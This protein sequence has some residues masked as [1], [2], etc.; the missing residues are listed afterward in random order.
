MYSTNK[1]LIAR[2]LNLHVLK[3]K[4]TLQTMQTRLFAE[5]L[6]DT[7]KDQA[8]K[9]DKKEYKKD[10]KKEED[11]KDDKKEDEKDDKKE[12]EKEVEKYLSKK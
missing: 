10:D 2:L 12:D 7:Q 1:K 3:N 11:K 9:P 8:E 4:N 5:N 6:D